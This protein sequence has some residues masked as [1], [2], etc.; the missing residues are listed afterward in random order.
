MFHVVHGFVCFH[1]HNQRK[2]S[3]ILDRTRSDYEKPLHFLTADDLIFLYGEKENWW[4]DLGACE[5]RCLYHKLLPTYY[6][7]YTSSYDPHILAMKTYETR[8]AVKK[9]A[10]LRARLYIRVFSIIF[11]GIRNIWKYKHWREASYE[12]LWQKYE[13]QIKS[14]TTIN[15]EDIDFKVAMMIAS[16]SCST[17]EWVDGCVF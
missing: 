13:K 9:Y 15:N 4:G 6:P 17:N 2:L 1:H 10:R 7:T 16:K 8:K 12:E 5:T 14:S 11:D 3:Q